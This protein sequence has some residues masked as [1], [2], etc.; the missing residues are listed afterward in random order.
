MFQGLSLD[1]RYDEEDWDGSYEIIILGSVIPKWFRHQSIWTEANTKEP[2]SLLCDEW[3]GIAICVVFCSLPRH[4]ISH[5]S[6]LSYKLIA[7]GKKVST[8]LG[9]KKKS[10]NTSII[11]YEDFGVLHHNFVNSAVAVERNNAKRTHDNYDG[12]G[13]SGE[14]SFNDLPNPKRIE[15]VTEIMTHGDSDCK[16]YI[17][18]GEELSEWQES[19]ESKLEGLL[20]LFM[21]RNCHMAKRQEG[22]CSPLYASHFHSP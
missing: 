4:Q 14:G 5:A 18:C 9:I 15:R 3:M 17:E 21:R 20:D 16:E 10:S 12:A 6:P 13:P 22:K 11:P 19:S 1:N 2:S 7:N 8:T